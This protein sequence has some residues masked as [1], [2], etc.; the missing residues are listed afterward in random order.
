MNGIQFWKLRW[1]ELECD[2][3][4]SGFYLSWPKMTS[5]VWT[6]QIVWLHFRILS[7]DFSSSCHLIFQ[8]WIPFIQIK[9]L[10][11]YLFST[12]SNMYR[13]IIY[14]IYV[15]VYWNLDRKAARLEEE[16]TDSNLYL[17]SFQGASFFSGH[18][19]VRSA[20]TL[21]A[22]IE[23]YGSVN[24]IIPENLEEI[25][26]YKIEDLNGFLNSD[27]QKLSDLHNHH[28]DVGKLGISKLPGIFSTKIK[29]LSSHEYCWRGFWKCTLSLWKISD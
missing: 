29:F 18:R 25:E 1:Q 5:N 28:M 8:N 14:R 9:V 19:A 3:T 16:N 11:I 6:N 21:M 24:D 17:S 26:K 27:N 12:G 22:H 20:D 15:L 7:F 4:R 23:V 10:S 13:Y 2:G